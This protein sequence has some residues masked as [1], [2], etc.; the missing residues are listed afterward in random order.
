MPTNLSL[1]IIGDLIQEAMNCYPLIGHLDGS[2][3]IVKP[4]LLKGRFLFFK[5]VM[6]VVKYVR[7]T[8]SF[9]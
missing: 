3:L 5:E 8:L 2:Q 6:P 9:K 4:T 7:K 1:V